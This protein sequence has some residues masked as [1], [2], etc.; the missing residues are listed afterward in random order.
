LFSFLLIS[1]FFPSTYLKIKLR[2][3]FCLFHPIILTH[4]GSIY[5]KHI[6]FLLEPDYFITRISG[7]SLPELFH[8][9][10]CGYFITRIRV[11]NPSN[12][13]ES[14]ISLL[15]FRVTRNRRTALVKMNAVNKLY[16]NKIIVAK[17]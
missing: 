5:K 9:P 7:I 11:S 14:S 12:F 4:F 6:F 15:E 17:R 2:T 3:F 16:N 8:Y 10:N 1:N 13:P